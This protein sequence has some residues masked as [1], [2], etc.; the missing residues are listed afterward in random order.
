MG[1]S[2]E[3]TLALDKAAT[4][5][6]ERFLNALKSDIDKGHPLLRPEAP[7]VLTESTDKALL[8]NLN[9]RI[10]K[11]FA[12]AWRLHLKMRKSRCLYCFEPADTGLDA[13][14][15]PEKS[16]IASEQRDWWERHPELKK[17]PDCNWFCRFPALVKYGDYTGHK[18]E[19]KQ[20][21][22]PLTF[23]L[24]LW[25][26]KNRF[27]AEIPSKH[28]QK[29]WTLDGGTYEDEQ[30]NQ[31]D[32]LVS[33]AGN[34]IASNNTSNTTN[35]HGG[36]HGAEANGGSGAGSKHGKEDDIE[37]TPDSQIMTLPGDLTS[38]RF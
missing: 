12:S 6:A 36:F 17:L 21:L 7:L 1:N 25:E 28:A 24:N 30:P 35:D 37:D 9:K 13:L 33:G 31:Q 11:C 2:R 15:I 29:H 26:S 3:K 19:D 23:G 18:F 5:L 38:L 22:L 16:T 14:S 4:E 27:G 32:D 8:I 20:V 34:A 10:K